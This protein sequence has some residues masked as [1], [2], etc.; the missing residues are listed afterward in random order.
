MNMDDEKKLKI[1]RSQLLDDARKLSRVQMVSD[2]IYRNHLKTRFFNLQEQRKLTNTIDEL[3]KQEKDSWRELNHRKLG[4]ERRAN[5]LAQKKAIN[6]VAASPLITLRSAGRAAPPKH[7]GQGLQPRQ[8]GRREGRTQLAAPKIWGQERRPSFSSLMNPYM[9]D[10]TE[11]GSK[12][13]YAQHLTK[14]G[15]RKSSTLGSNLE[16][17]DLQQYYYNQPQFS[18]SQAVIF[19]GLKQS[20]RGLIKMG[21]IQSDARYSRRISGLPIPPTIKEDQARYIRTPGQID[22]DPLEEEMSWLP[23]VT[24]EHSVSYPGE[25]RRSSISSDPNFLR[26]GGPNR[27]AHRRGSRSLGELEMKKFLP[28]AGRCP[29]PVFGL[30]SDFSDKLSLFNQRMDQ[31]QQRHDMEVLLDPLPDDHTAPP[32]RDSLD[33]HGSVSMETSR[34]EDDKLPVVLAG[35]GDPVRM[36][37]VDRFDLSKWRRDMAVQDTLPVI[38]SCKYIRNPSRERYD[39]TSNQYYVID[40][41]GGLEEDVP[42]PLPTI[43]GARL[44]N[45]VQEAMKYS[46][47]VDKI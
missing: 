10:P 16:L 27:L 34:G 1:T 3:E 4:L 13:G 11:Y 23:T 17:E 9:T 28:F 5:K 15:Y 35:R 21:V 25:R 41:E 7:N 2:R 26:T 8:G 42:A 24:Y 18:K 46:R 36:S 22:E 14:K 12:L 37:V 40:E 29:S 19:R 38:K 20:A 6:Q 44:Y 33:R 30:D 31:L 39:P 47:E 45:V 32:P 43:P